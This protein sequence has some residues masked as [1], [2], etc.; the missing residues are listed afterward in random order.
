MGAYPDTTSNAGGADKQTDPNNVAYTST[1]GDGYLLLGHDITGGDGPTA[2]VIFLNFKEA[3]YCYTIDA[4]GT[5]HQYLEDG[6]EQ[7]P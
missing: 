5:V 1:D 4:N 3:T 6:T 7:V 2:V